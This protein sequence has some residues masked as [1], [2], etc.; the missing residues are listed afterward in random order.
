M[1]TN[2]H[3]VSNSEITVQDGPLR[4]AVINVKV[5]RIEVCYPPE[6]IAARGGTPRAQRRRYPPSIPISIWRSST[7]AGLN[8][9]YLAFGDSDV[10]TSGQPVQALGFP[11]G[12]Y[13][14]HR[15]QYSGLGG[16][17]HHDDCRHDLGAEN[18][19]RR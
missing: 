8:Q 2:E 19:C 5:S 17:R 4:K 11:F 7:P 3:V 1:L 14:E 9:P 16:A 12:L 6:S 18:E 15:P 13:A 10:I